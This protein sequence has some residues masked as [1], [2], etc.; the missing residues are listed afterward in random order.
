MKTLLL[1]IAFTIIGLSVKAQDIEIY[2]EGYTTDISGTLVYGSGDVDEMKYYLGVKNNSNAPLDLTVKRL[3]IDEVAGAKDYF[4]WGVTFNSGACYDADAVTASNPWTSVDEFSFPAGTVGILYS[5]HKPEGNYGIAKYR[6][7]IMSNGMAL[8]SVDV[9]YNALLSV[10]P[11][12]PASIS[13]FPNPANE[14]LNVNVENLSNSGSIAIYDI[15][16]KTVLNS[17]LKNGKNQLDV[18]ALKAGV[19]FYTIR[20][21]KDIIETKKLLIQ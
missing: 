5:Y 17:L 14:I 21:N 7:Y 15:T 1:T 18:E 11:E 10:K 9:Q 13:V 3:R 8:D 6:Y 2:H 20:N 4:C 19:Y 16:G 12:K